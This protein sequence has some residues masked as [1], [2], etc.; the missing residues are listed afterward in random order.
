MLRAKIVK[1]T[2]PLDK[3]LIDLQDQ[4]CSITEVRDLDF[5]FLILYDDPFVHSRVPDE[6]TEEPADE[7]LTNEQKFLRDWGRRPINANVVGSL[8]YE[9]ICPA[10]TG[11]P[12]DQKEYNTKSG[13]CSAGPSNCRECAKRFWKSKYKKPEKK[14]V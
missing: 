6:D 14:E 4:G 7:D 9:Y 12:F 1:Y 5:D 10:H 8:A 11:L 13:L 2:E 3:I